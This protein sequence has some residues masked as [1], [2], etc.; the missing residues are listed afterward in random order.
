MASFPE[1][2]QVFLSQGFR[3]PFSQCLGQPFLSSCG[4]LLPSF[5]SKSAQKATPWRKHPRPLFLFKFFPSRI[6]FY[7]STLFIS[8]LA[9]L[10][11]CGRGRTVSTHLFSVTPIRTK[12]LRSRKLSPFITCCIARGPGSKPA[13]PWALSI[14]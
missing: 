11:A 2:I 7:P 6:V 13:T 9:L 12:I 4:C 8:F 14:L 3:A 5:K 10:T 1:I